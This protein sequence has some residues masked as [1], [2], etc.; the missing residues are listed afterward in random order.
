[1]FKQPLLR[2]RGGVTGV[3]EDPV[4]TLTAV[5][6]TAADRVVQGLVL[7]NR[8]GISQLV[9]GYEQT[10]AAKTATRQRGHDWPAT[11]RP[12]WLSP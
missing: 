4:V 1:M 8:E 2:A 12:V 10:A 11:H 6:A 7:Q 3:H 9:L 5:H